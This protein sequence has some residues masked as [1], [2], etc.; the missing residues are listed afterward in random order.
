MKIVFVAVF[1]QENKS[2]NNSQSRGFSAAGANVIEYSFRDRAALIGDFA[3][4]NELVEFINDNSPDLVVF[5]KCAELAV[6]TF[7]KICSKYQTCYWYMDPLVSLKQDLLKKASLCTFVVTAVPNTVEP[8]KQVNENTTLLYE[9]YDHTIDYPQNEE[10]KFDVSFIG[11]LHSNRREMLGNLDPSVV[12]VNGAFGTDH[13]RAVAMSKINLNVAT[14][15]G[16]SDRVFKVMAAGG[17]LMSTDWDGREKLF[18]DGKHIVIFS[19]R[20]DLQ[21]K[22]SYYLKNEDKRIE[23]ATNALNEVQK[24]NRDAWAVEVLRIYNEVNNGQS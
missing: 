21:K 6:T 16:A 12:H 22:L 9:G 18:E 13:A 24:Y 17:F 8:L 5:S 2:T 23:I 4:D 14:T 20:N 10:K 1:D 3:R 15:G 11:S 7:E 19:D